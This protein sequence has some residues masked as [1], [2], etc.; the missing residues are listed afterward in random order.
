MGLRGDDNSQSE[1]PEA[2]EKIIL[3]LGTEN[4][5]GRIPAHIFAAKTVI[6]YKPRITNN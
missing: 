3:L 6:V 4:I 5:R 1:E 2:S